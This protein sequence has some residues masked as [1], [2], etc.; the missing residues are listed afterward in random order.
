MNNE[1]DTT[2][3]VAQILAEHIEDAKQR[4]YSYTFFCPDH[5]SAHDVLRAKANRE[6]SAIEEIARSLGLDDRVQEILNERE[7]LAERKR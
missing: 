2:K 6:K 1:F 5:E 7:F 4:V 3:A